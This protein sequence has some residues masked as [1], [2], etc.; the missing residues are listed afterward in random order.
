MLFLLIHY[1]SLSH[2]CERTTSCE[3]KDWQQVIR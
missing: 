2:I 3:E 1:L